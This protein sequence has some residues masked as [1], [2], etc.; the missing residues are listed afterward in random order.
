M[1]YLNPL[2]YVNGNI[3]TPLVLRPLFAPGS[4]LRNIRNELLGSL[5][6]I[7]T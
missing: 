7:C 2:K 1:D 6:L 3:V 4:D 5:N